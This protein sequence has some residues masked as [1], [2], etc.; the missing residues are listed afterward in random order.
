MENDSRKL[1]RVFTGSDIAS[2]LLKAQIEESGVPAMIQNDYQS[3]IESSFVGNIRK[4]TDLYI[5]D[6]DLPEVEELIKDFIERN[7]E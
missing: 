7:K 6:S 3:G 1:I 4:E 2:K 5:Y